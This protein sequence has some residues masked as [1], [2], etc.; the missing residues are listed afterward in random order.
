MDRLTQSR[1]FSTILVS[2]ECSGRPLQRRITPKSSFWYTT[3]SRFILQP[4]NKSC[5]ERPNQLKTNVVFLVW[6]SCFK[7][8]LFDWSHFPKYVLRLQMVCKEFSQHR[9][10]WIE[11][12]TSSTISFD[13]CF[14][15]EK[16]CYYFNKCYINI[17]TMHLLTCLRHYSC[18]ITLV[19]RLPSAASSRGRIY[20]FRDFSDLKQNDPSRIMDPWKI[21]SK[22]F[23][24]TFQILNYFLT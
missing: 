24:D 18:Y 13:R 16:K 17:K 12:K 22:I 21:P 14:R 3:L 7:I 15:A 6:D 2:S 1:T 23:P 11:N 8:K 20:G 9:L 19:Q 10:K 4:W 5:S